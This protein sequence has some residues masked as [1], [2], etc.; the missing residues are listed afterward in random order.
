VNEWTKGLAALKS[1]KDVDYNGASGK[2]DL[3]GN[4]DP[5]SGTYS[6]WKIQNGKYVDVET[7]S[8]P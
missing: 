1:G 4:G 8:F 7:I 2:I 6:W 3:D 5:T